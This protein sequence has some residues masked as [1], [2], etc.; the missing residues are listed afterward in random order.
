MRIHRMG[1]NPYLAALNPAAG[2]RDKQG[3]VGYE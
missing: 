2:D 1:G 3:M